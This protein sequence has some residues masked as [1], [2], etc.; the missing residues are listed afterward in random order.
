MYYFH[1]FRLIFNCRHLTGLPRTNRMTSSPVGLL[2]QLVELHQYRRG[3]GFNSPTGL[4]FSS[5]WLILTTKLAACITTKIT[6]LS[7]SFINPQFTYMIFMY[8]RSFRQSNKAHC[9]ICNKTKDAVDQNYNKIL[10]RV[11]LWLIPP[12]NFWKHGLLAK[13]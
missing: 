6:W 12:N 4:N 13:D 2:A 5:S 9:K 1:M 10:E 3:H 7:Y 8:S 11:Y